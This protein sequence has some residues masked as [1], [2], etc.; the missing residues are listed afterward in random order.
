MCLRRIKQFSQNVA[1]YFVQSVLKMKELLSVRYAGLILNKFLIYKI[2]FYII[3][4]KLYKM[5]YKCVEKKISY[6]EDRCPTFSIE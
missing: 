3:Y 4:I 1:I 6:M 5:Y 2:D